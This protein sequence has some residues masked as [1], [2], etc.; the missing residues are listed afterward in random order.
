[1]L[2]NTESQQDLKALQLEILCL[3]SMLSD[4]ST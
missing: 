2:E 4:K 3:L 1:M